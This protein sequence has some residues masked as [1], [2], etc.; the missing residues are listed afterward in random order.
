[1]VIEI[2][3][4]TVEKAMLAVWFELDEYIP[5]GIQEL[6]KS[7]KVSYDTVKAYCFMFWHMGIVIALNGTKAMFVKVSGTNRL[8]TKWMNLHASSKKR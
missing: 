2:G 4:N 8:Q 1:M 3:K 5:K 6:S 7:T